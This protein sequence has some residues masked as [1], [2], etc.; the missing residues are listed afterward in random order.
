MASTPKF[1]QGVFGFTGSGLTKQ[2]PLDPSLSYVVPQGMTVQPL[3]FRGGN[4]SDEL[5]YVTLLR[6]Q[7]PMRW[8]PLGARGSV[9]IPLRVVEDV[10]ADSVLE[11]VFAAPEGCTGELVIDFGMVQF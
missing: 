9:N 1:L 11:L 5:V 8:F 10:D 6:D 7:A 2:A 4:S 3:Y